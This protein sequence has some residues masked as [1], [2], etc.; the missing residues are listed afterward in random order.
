M[1][2]LLLLP[3]LLALGLSRSRRL[4]FGFRFGFGFGFGFGQRDVFP[5]SSQME[6]AFS[7]AVALGFIAQTQT[8]VVWVTELCLKGLDSS[9]KGRISRLLC[10]LGGKLCFEVS[11]T[12]L[13]SEKSE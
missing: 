8:H 11:D 2:P 5:L 9:L 10:R 4:G 6:T 1:R 7:V 3:L 13:E 12:I